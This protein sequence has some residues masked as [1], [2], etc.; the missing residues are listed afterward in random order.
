M[1]HEQHPFLGKAGKRWPL[2]SRRL[3]KAR[4]LRGL[5]SNNCKFS[6][7][8][9]QDLHVEPAIAPS[10]RAGNTQPGA[11]LLL[12]GHR[13]SGPGH[14]VPN[15]NHLERLKRTIPPPKLRR[16]PGVH[17]GQQLKRLHKERST[18]TSVPDPNTNG[19]PRA[20]P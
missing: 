6:N 8:S 20:G 11:A 5:I 16:Q 12:S 10:H 4:Y 19:A 17:V 2:E 13:N 9:R 15:P 1:I 7:L 18:S 3:E 14:N